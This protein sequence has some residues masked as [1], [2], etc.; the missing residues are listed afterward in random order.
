MESLRVLNENRAALLAVVSELDAKIAA[1]PETIAEFFS[2]FVQHPGC[3]AH[4]ARVTSVTEADGWTDSR[5]NPMEWSGFRFT[6]RDDPQ[7]YWM[8][9]GSNWCSNVE[10]C[11]KDGDESC[12]DVPLSSMQDLEDEAL[13]DYIASLDPVMAIGCMLRARLGW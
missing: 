4:I 13:A 10:D 8:R 2:E 11:G 12:P 5:K 1:H 7:T 3:A 6:L 9:S